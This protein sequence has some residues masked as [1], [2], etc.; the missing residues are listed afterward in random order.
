MVSPCTY[1]KCLYVMHL[2]LPFFAFMYLHL[3]SHLGTLDEPC[4]ELKDMMLETNPK[5][6][7]GGPISKMEGP[8]ECMPRAEMPPRWCKLIKLTCVRS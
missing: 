4:G 2:M 1:L 8:L 5:M 6:V 3:A 7:F